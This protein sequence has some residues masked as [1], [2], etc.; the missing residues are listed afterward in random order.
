L[1]KGNKLLNGIKVPEW[2]FGHKE[3]IKACVRGLMDTDGCIFEHS[4]NVNGKLYS[5]VKMAFSS[6]SPRMLDDMQRMLLAL[7]FHPGTPRADYI[8]LSRAKEVR[9]YHEEVVGTNNPYHQR[10]YDEA[11]Q[12]KERR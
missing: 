5:Y 7:G 2:I 8:W 6:H 12:K 4:Y 11:R 3:L 10:R 1:P 9:A